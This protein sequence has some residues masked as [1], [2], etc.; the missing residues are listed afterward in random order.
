ML[1]CLQL[2]DLAPSM[3]CSVKIIFG[4]PDQFI[5]SSLTTIVI[6][7]DYPRHCNDLLHVMPVNQAIASHR[8]S[9]AD[10]ECSGLP[11]GSPGKCRQNSAGHN[12]Q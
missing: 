5:L 2:H 3:F 10:P 11:P 1:Y 12:I 6:N 7:S 4:Y 8:L 9:T